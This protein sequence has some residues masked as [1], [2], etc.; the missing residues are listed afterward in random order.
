MKKEVFRCVFNLIKVFGF[1]NCI[2]L[3]VKFKCLFYV[4][5]DWIIGLN[6]LNLNDGLWVI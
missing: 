4:D 1:L 6:V 3:Y 5:C 2:K